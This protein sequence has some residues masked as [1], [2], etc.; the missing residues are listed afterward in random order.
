M[1]ERLGGVKMIEWLSVLGL[2]SV[3]ALSAWSCIHTYRKG[4]DGL[5]TALLIANVILGSLTYALVI[6]R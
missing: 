3:L 2:V 1:A 4:L 6:F 5:S